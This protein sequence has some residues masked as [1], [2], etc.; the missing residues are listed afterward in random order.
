MS[1]QLKISIIV[2]VYNTEQYLLHCLDSILSQDFTDYELLL[3]DD[4]SKDNSGAICDEYAE[5]DS[6]ICVFHK[7]NGGVSSA[8]NLGLD[9]AQGEWVAFVDSDD[10]L[11]DNALDLLL[12]EAKD[13]VD[14]VYGGI[15]KFDESSDDI[16]TI[17]VKERGRISVEEA[18]DAFVVPKKRNGDW[19]RYLYNRIYRMP[20]IKKFG[21]RFKEDIYYKEDGLFVVQYLCQCEK[22]VACVP[23]IVY[24][25]R[26]VKNSAMGSLASAYNEKLLTNVD[27]H[28]YIIRELEKRGVCKNLIER[29]MN[30][31]FG[32]YYWISGIMKRS[33]DFTKKNKKLLLKKI[34]KNAGLVNYLRYFVILRYS[35]KIKKKLLCILQS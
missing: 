35:R 32:N 20:I 13:D 29:E 21:L 27:A 2:P 12:N 7:E 17:T 19:H 1:C 9:H 14:M 28:G 26:Q 30:E 3:I 11:V 15:R 33:G 31:V 6:R 18:L 8:R 16:E 5:K 23:D 25:Y 24:L 4:G 22:K 34:I 10:L